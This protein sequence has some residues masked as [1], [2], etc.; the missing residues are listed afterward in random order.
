LRL[1]E[2][3]LPPTALATQVID[4]RLCRLIARRSER[5]AANLEAVFIC[6]ISLLVNSFRRCWTTR[7]GRW[8]GRFRSSYADGGLDTLLYHFFTTLLWLTSL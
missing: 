6:G 4:L 8:E 2:V 3:R 5:S 1:A 7:V